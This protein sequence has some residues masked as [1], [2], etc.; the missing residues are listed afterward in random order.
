[1][2]ENAHGVAI[3]E[4]ADTSDQHDNPLEALPIDRFVDLAPADIAILA[5]KVHQRYD[6]HG[7]C[8][9]VFVQRE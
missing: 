1:V 7:S 5:K 2:K 9:A 8:L 3:E 6:F 4:E